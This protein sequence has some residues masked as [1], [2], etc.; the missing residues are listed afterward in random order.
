MKPPLRSQEDV[1]ALLS[2]VKDGTIDIFATDH[3][4][5][6]FDEKAVELDF[7]PFG[8]IGLETAVPLLLD[9][10]VHKNIISLE[11]FIQM[12]SVRPAEI[13][14][15]ENKGKICIGADAD[16]TILNLHKEIFIDANTFKSKSRNCPF[17]GWKLRGKPE[18]TIVE[19]KIVSSG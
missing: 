6:T 5:H 1:L 4:P 10:L 12:M 19:G 9:K 16:L 8:I 2:A 7:A 11:R 3:A 14:G 13:F 18:M 17:H 15:L